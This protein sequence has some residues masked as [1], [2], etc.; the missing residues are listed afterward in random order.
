[1][2]DTNNTD[3]AEVENS[4]NP[5]DAAAANKPLDELTVEDCYWDRDEMDVLQD[6]YFIL[7]DA[8]FT[9]SEVRPLGELLNNTTMYSVVRTE[10]VF[11]EF[12]DDE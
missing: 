7:R 6:A 8:G 12:V 10:T 5:F 3:D 1:M 2:S 4:K 11:D 9:A